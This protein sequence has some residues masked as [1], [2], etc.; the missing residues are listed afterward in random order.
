MTEESRFSN[1]MQNNRFA[2][3]YILSQLIKGNEFF[4]LLE[5]RSIWE[6]N[7]F[8]IIECYMV[9]LYF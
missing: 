5:S 4:F 1:R 3:V 6:K 9:R 7:R 2:L 8:E